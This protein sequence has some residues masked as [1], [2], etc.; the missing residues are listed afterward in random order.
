MSSTICFDA[1]AEIDHNA[2]IVK[3]S[4]PGNTAVRTKITFNLFFDGS[5]AQSIR[6]PNNYPEVASVMPILGIMRCDF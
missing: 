2:K 1:N 6:E 3:F 5:V 4:F